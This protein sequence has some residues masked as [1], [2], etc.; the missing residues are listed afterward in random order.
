MKRYV[1]LLATIA[2]VVY[3][4][5]DW[6]NANFSI[7]AP[8]SAT[9]TKSTTDED[10][11]INKLRIDTIMYA[12]GHSFGYEGD[13]SMWGG[14]YFDTVRVGDDRFLRYDSVAPTSLRLDLITRTTIVNLAAPNAQT[15]IEEFLAPV[16]G[17]QRFQKHYEVCLDSVVDKEYGLLKCMG[18][19]SFTSDYP[20]S[21]MEN[22]AKINRYI[23]DLAGVAQDI[24]T[25]I[26]ALTAFYIGYKPSQN[27][28]K[29]YTGDSDDMLQLSDFI[30]KKTFD[31]WKLEENLAY[32]GSSKRADIA[33]R[34]HISNPY[35]VTFSQYAYEREGMGHGMYTETFHSLDL[36]IGK[37]IDNK[38][39]FKRGTLDKVKRQLSE[40]MAKDAN[41]TSWNQ[42]IKSAD[43]VEMQIKGWRSPS[44]ILKGTEWEE[45]ETEFVLELPMG[46]LTDKGV[47]FSFQPYEID[48]WAAGAFHFVVP[49]EKLMPYFTPE[50]KRVISN[51]RRQ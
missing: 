26:P 38:F 2:V 51:I 44:P 18:Y 14:W 50:A 29:P 28:G 32:E 3:I 25:E 33:I 24:R 45:P 23:C 34:V 40:V 47:V 8:S 27:T 31:W 36:Q 21:C 20:D 6:S 37:N 16:E 30:A 43:D 17:F 19:F 7:V 4:I 35:F 39:L 9:T 5:V 48:C 11:K 42:N 22:V 15:Q 46:A 13:I 1:F 12:G 41:F 49:Y 10:S